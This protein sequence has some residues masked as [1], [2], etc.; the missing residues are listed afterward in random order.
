MIPLLRVAPIVEGHGEVDAVPELIRRIAEHSA[1]GTPLQVLPA[2]RVSR[3]RV[4][5]PNVLERY[6]DLAARKSMPDGRILLLLDADRD[7]PMQLAS[8]LL[9]RA[10][11][12]R[13]DRLISV[14]IAKAEFESWFLASAGSIAGVRGI[15]TGCKAPRDPEV[16]RDAKGWLT[17]Q[18]APGRRYSPTVDQLD[19]TRCF[20]IDA[21]R[22]AP[23]FDKFW[24]DVERLLASQ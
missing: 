16:I 10:R 13:S 21:A 20:D 2:I 1:P 19:L 14:V 24:R 5:K 15:S 6:V 7:C 22:A 23:S 11:G 18:M 4:V 8:T 9:S 12:A 17:R 3:N